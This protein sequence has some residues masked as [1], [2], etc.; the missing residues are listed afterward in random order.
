MDRML[1][2]TPGPGRSSSGSRPPADSWPAPRGHIL[3][4]IHVL[5]D[6]LGIFVG[7]F[8]PAAAGDPLAIGR[9]A[10]AHNDQ[11]VAAHAGDVFLDLLLHPQ[12]QG[13][14]GDDG[15]HPDDDPQHSQEGPDLVG[16]HPFKGHFHTFSKQPPDLLP[17]SLPSA[18]RPASPG[19]AGS[20]PPV[21]VRE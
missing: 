3:D 9:P 4:A 13:Y 17:L 8:G 10:A 15:A 5:F 1:G 2:V 21:P 14:H 16:Q 6:G 7:Q 18:G 12:S 20:W 11:Q 19:S